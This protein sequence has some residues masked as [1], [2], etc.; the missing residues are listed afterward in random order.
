VEFRLELLPRMMIR[1]SPTSI[2]NSRPSNKTAKHTHND[3]R[4]SCRTAVH[5]TDTTD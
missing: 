3:K 5:G 1:P 4:I 2:A